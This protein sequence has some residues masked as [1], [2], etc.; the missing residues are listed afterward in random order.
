MILFI[1]FDGVLHSMN[2]ESGSLVHAT[3]QGG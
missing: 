3:L 1:D 2:R